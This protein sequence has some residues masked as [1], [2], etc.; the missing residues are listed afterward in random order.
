MFQMMYLPIAFRTFEAMYS[1]PPPPPPVI[2]CYKPTVSIVHGLDSISFFLLSRYPATCC[3]WF[4][5]LHLLVFFFNY[6]RLHRCSYHLQKTLTQN[7]RSLIRSSFLLSLSSLVTILWT[8]SLVNHLQSDISVREEGRGGLILASRD[9]WA[10]SGLT[11]VCFLLLV[12]KDKSR[13]NWSHI[14]WAPFV[15]DLRIHQI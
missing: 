4:V 14:S 6:V 3:R 11:V 13:G 7:L 15:A 5:N 12:I 8:Y 9:M 1:E 10:E 2:P